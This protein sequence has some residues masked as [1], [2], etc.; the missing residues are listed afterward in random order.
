VPKTRKDNTPRRRRGAAA[1]AAVDR[2]ERGLALRLLL[3]NPKDFVAAMVASAAV[4][5]IV[6]NAI[7]MQAGHHPSPMFGNA[8][9]S[10]SLSIVTLPRP[11]P[12]D[13]QT[14]PD[15]K[16]FEQKLLEPTVTELKPADSK[17]AEAKPSETKPA[18]AKP[19]E[20][21]PVETRHAEP[22]RAEVHPVRGRA[23][24]ADDPLGNLV[25]ATG[26]HPTIS[27]NAPRPP[28]AIPS[29]P[30]E[31]VGDMISPSRRVAA[32]QRTLTQYGYGQLKPTGTVGSDTRS[33]IER[34][35][36]TRHLPVTGQVSDR[37][38]RE[39]GTM[40]GR[41]IE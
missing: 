37:L 8:V 23:A 21:R 9:S 3:S 41:P 11:R 4:I 19:V 30:R 39:L 5:A 36:R 33:A 25:R 38:V 1:A 15:N 10:P 31:S 32:V 17:A 28:A 16:A 27:A 34:F 20:L 35:E 2:D 29:A 6:T 24:E 26:P 22:R 7:F 14:R 40:T 13:A 12:A 18:E